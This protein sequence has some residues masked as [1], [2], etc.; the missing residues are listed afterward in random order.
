MLTIA[1]V[2]VAL[3]KVPVMV[4]VSPAVTV[5]CVTV[6]LCV[7]LGIVDVGGAVGATVGNGAGAAT[8]NVAADSVHLCSVAQSVEYTPRPTRYVPSA[9][10]DGTVHAT[11]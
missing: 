8:A 3:V 4:T 2:A 5:D 10:S 7:K 11:G 9:A 1:V 6:A